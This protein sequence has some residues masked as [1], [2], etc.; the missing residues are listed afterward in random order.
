MMSVF[1][2]LNVRRNEVSRVCLA[3]CVFFLVAVDDGIIKSVSSGVFNVR[4]G[5]DHLPEMYG[6][7][8][9]LFSA[10]MALLSWLTTKIPRQRLVFTLFT[11]LALFLA[12]NTLMLFWVQAGADNEPSKGFYSFL[13]VSSELIRNIAVFQV[14]I[15]AGGICYSSRAKVLF[16]LLAA[17]TTLGDIGGG[18]LVRQLSGL[19]DSWQVYGL[20]AVNTLVIISLLRPLMRRYFVTSAD[21]AEGTAS[22]SMTENLRYFAGSSYLR[23]LFVLSLVL[24]ALYTAIHY[25]FSVVARIHYHDEGDITSFFGLFFGLAGVATLLT[26]TVLLRHLLRW[27]GIANVYLWVCVIHGVIA[28]ILAAVFEGSL[29]LSPVTIILAVNLLNYVLLDSVIAP[30]Y[31]VLMKLVPE[32]NSDG[33]RMIMEG[34]FMLIGGLLGAGITLLHAQSVLTLAQLFAVL[35]V[36]GLVMVSV[37][38]RLRTRYREVLVQAVREQNVD[39]ADEEA[40]REVVS[41]SADVPRG[42]LLH[43]SDGVRQMG[44][45]ILRHNPQVA[46]EVGLSLLQHE[47]PRIRAAALQA[48]TGVDDGSVVVTALPCLDDADDEVRLRAARVVA[49]L[50][51]T[52]GKDGLAGSVREQIIAEVGPRLQPDTGHPAIQAELLFVLESLQDDTSKTVRQSILESLLQSDEVEQISA[53]VDVV[54]RLGQVAEYRRVFDHLDHA[55]PVVREAAVRAVGEQGDRDGCLALVRALSD[56]DPDVVDAAVS[57]LEAAAPSHGAF[58]VQGLHQ[59]PTKQWDGLVRSLA[60]TEDEIV[61]S[62]LLEMCRERLVEANRY[63]M[64]TELLRQRPEAAAGLLCDQLDLEC[65]TVRDGAI[66]LLGQL[67]D[68]GVVSD[69]V[70]Q[71]NDDRPGARDSAIELLENIGNRA[72]LQPLLPLLTDDDEER[73]SAAAQVSGWSAASMNLDR[74]LTCVLESADPWMQLAAAWAAHSLDRRALLERMRSDAPDFVKEIS[75]KMETDTVQDASNQ[76]LTN[77]EKITFLKESPFFAALPLEEL[78]HIALSVQEESVPAETTVIEQGTAGDKMYIVVAGGLE[79]RRY[80]EGGQEGGLRVAELGEKQ[81]VGEMSLLDDEPRSASVISMTQCRLL[82]LERGDLERILRRYSSI[83]FSMMRILSKRLREN[84]AA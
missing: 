5:P 4:V 62:A 77:M 33:T 84:M 23:L 25:G 27:L 3:A 56:P 68:V 49:R 71:M 66:S 79:V 69:L 78:Y 29:S 9:L 13:F 73:Q 41:G 60:R 10:T 19:L 28:G 18:F 38:W 61:S 72:L 82:S 24:F 16:P 51:E 55:Y 58:L 6:W 14:W 12:C 65:R 30:T 45:E 8:A 64:I 80:D 22:A 1:R 15:V 83:A 59:E 42:L 54:R 20:A 21:A 39:L 50:L 70:D 81:V 48:L 44:I 31:Q 34:G 17:S 63:V 76:P 37:A 74:S 11:T 36:I 43:N 53:G 35:F 40:M 52:I 32:R 57:G 2:L 46:V 47:N 26:T 67:G 7:I 75:E